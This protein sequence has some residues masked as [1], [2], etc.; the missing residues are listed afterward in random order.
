MM[1]MIMVASLM[2]SMFV[3]QK[4]ITYQIHSQ[5]HRLLPI[6]ITLA[7][8]TQF[9]EVVEYLTRES[10]VFSFLEQ[11]LLIQMLYIVIYY[12]KDVMRI[13]FRKPTK[14][15]LF[16]CLILSDLIMFAGYGQK[17]EIYN[18]V[19]YF[20]VTF[21]I[22][23]M[24]Y[25]ATKAYL[26][27]DYSKKEHYVN[28]VLYVALIIPCFG[29]LW[30]SRVLEEWGEVIVPVSLSI[31]SGIVYYLIETKRLLDPLTLMKESLFD[32]SDIAIVLFDEDFYFLEANHA[33]HVLFPEHS[34]MITQE[35]SR[36]L[37][38]D[39]LKDFIDNPNE[40]IEYA[41]KHH[42][43]Y[44]CALQPAIFETKKKGYILTIVNITKQKKETQLME[45]LKEMAEEQTASKSRFLAC[46][47]HDL[48]SPLHA[49]IGVSDIMLSQKGLEGRNRSLMRY[50]K[51]AGNSLLELVNSILLV[52]KLKS[53]KIEMANSPYDLE[54][55]LE[56]LTDMCIVNLQN[57][58][59][60]FSITLN[61]THP[62]QFL[63][64]AI[65]VRQMLQNL[66]AN[67]VKYT[68]K[69]EIRCEVTCKEQS[70]KYRIDCVVS[71]TGPGMTRRQIACAFEEYVS[72]NTDGIKEE[73][74]LGLYI[75]KE[76][77][78]KMGGEAQVESTLGKGTTFHFY[79]MQEKAPNAAMKLP[80]TFNEDLLLRS[81]VQGMESIAPNWIYP[82]A[83]VL[84]VDDMK[85][86]QEIFKEMLRPWKCQV[87][88]A[89]NGQEAIAAISQNAYQMV[90]LDRMMPDM[91]GI[92]VAAQ[93]QKI[94]NVPII[95]VTADLSEDVNGCYHKYGFNA[96]LLKPV[97]ITLLQDVLETLMPHRYRK[98]PEATDVT[99]AMEDIGY[100]NNRKGYRR[101]LEAFVQ[102]AKPLVTSIAEYA[103]NNHAMFQTK[104][105]GIKGAS[106]QIGEK[107]LSE[108]AEEMEMA[109]KTEN[110]SY[111]ERHMNGFIE[112]LSNAVQEVGNELARMTF[113]TGTVTPVQ[114]QF[115]TTEVFEQ[116]E[117]AFDEYDMVQI[118][119]NL[120]ILHTQ[121]L[122]A[123]EKELL[124]KV[125]EAYDN[126]EYETG[127]ALLNDFKRIKD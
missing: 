22:A 111:I 73:T 65:S 67:A 35:H 94:R 24:V 54:K 75:V 30:Q 116:L 76:L 121:E 41:A 107:A 15:V 66:L 60:N 85:V 92:E 9:Y 81:Q 44:R 5:T 14:T 61:S 103:Q 31:S 39:M 100:E 84:V 13:R 78:H 108:F 49:I 57:R 64:D 34:A 27:E 68:E 4:Y 36:I 20:T 72:G 37:C 88:I 21:Y 105:H 90:F 50:V 55:L 53:G 96:L 106:L 23:F 118:E 77:A 82:D 83:R 87:D 98:R 29:L 18:F 80:I 91:T 127:A 17:E 102:E 19:L 25:L 33:A 117:K 11:L 10:K 59:V 122:D 40:P 110:Y 112:E 79:I 113:Q 89:G 86:N 16:V 99:Q 52:S 1:L 32:T 62:S 70:G 126:L 93:V 63:G 8:L 97:D 26:F 74:G 125:Q 28:L 120:R 123:Q 2:F 47:S 48:R 115:S 38:R 95:L 109:A 56:D 43:Y 104:V 12:I 42:E 7:I 51:S 114:E 124:D 119:E 45:R 46:M 58:P 6:V 101:M 71:D 3:L 69:G